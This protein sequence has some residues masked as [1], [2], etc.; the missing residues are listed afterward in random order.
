MFQNIAASLRALPIQLSSF[1]DQCGT[2]S[3]EK[4]IMTTTFASLSGPDFL[5]LSRRQIKALSLDELQ[6]LVLRSQRLLAKALFK[7][8]QCLFE[9]MPD[10]FVIEIL[11]EWLP[12]EELASFDRALTNHYYREK[13]LSLLRDTVHRGVLSVSRKMRRIGYQ[14]DSGVAEW[15]ESRNVFMRMLRFRDQVMDLPAGFL[16]CTGSQLLEI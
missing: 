8:V 5:K 3:S 16:A 2:S 6:L 11:L 15:L 10:E 4:T 12:I 7:P 9:V 13:Y 1:I 14:F